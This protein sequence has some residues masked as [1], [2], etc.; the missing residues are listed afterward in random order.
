MKTEESKPELFRRIYI[1]TEA[2]LPKKED[3]YHVLP[4]NKSPEH[5]LYS[6]YRDEYKNY[7]LNNID[8]YFQPIEQSE[9]AQKQ[10][11]IVKC[12]CSNS[13]EYSNCAKNC[14][15]KIADET[16]IEQKEYT[17]SEGNDNEGNRWKV[18]SKPV[19][20]KTAEDFSWLFDEALRCLKNSDIN[21]KHWIMRA[22]EEYHAQFSEPMTDSYTLKPT[23]EDIENAARPYA[24]DSY[25][26][27][28]A[29]IAGA[30]DCRDDKIP[31]SP[32]NKI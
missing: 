3:Y 5:I 23:D 24:N 10:N 27:F 30:K 16:D 29:Y 13:L 31:I 6:Y 20:R 12:T 26:T 9:P 19:Q 15:R 4:I 7:W 21:A 17:E 28:I 1:E 14:E 2:D 25:G 22:K 32:K 11:K 18:Y 8:W